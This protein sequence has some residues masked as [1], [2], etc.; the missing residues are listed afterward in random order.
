M[1]INYLNAKIRETHLKPY[2]KEIMMNNNLPCPEDSLIVEFLKWL[3]PTVIFGGL[4]GLFSYYLIMLAIPELSEH[5]I[6]VYGFIVT[7]AIIIGLPP[8]TALIKDYPLWLN[9]LGNAMVIIG[10]TAAMIGLGF[11]V[12]YLLSPTVFQWLSANWLSFFPVLCLWI[13]IENVLTTGWIWLRNLL[14]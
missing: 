9:I 8:R 3:L 7:S 4:L 10:T 6:M 1:K 5:S 2:L 14:H 13:F 12:T 11:L